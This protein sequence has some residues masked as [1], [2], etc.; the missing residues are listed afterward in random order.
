MSCAQTKTQKSRSLFWVLMSCV[1]RQRQISKPLCRKVRPNFLVS[2]GASKTPLATQEKFQPKNG[3]YISPRSGQISSTT[4]RCLQHFPN[5]LEQVTFFLALSLPMRNLDRHLLTVRPKRVLPDNSR[6]C[7]K[8]LNSEEIETLPF[9]ASKQFTCAPI[10][11]SEVYFTSASPLQ[12]QSNLLHSLR[13]ALKAFSCLPS[14]SRSPCQASQANCMC[15][16]VP[17]LPPDILPIKTAAF[18]K[19]GLRSARIS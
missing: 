15:N 19:N 13:A 2:A 17:T 4:F 14:T 8:T 12:T 1:M 6:W 5:E 9:S 3:I 16:Y 7:H 10:R 11:P 18:G